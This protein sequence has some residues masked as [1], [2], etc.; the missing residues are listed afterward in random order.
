MSKLKIFLSN[1]NATEIL[2]ALDYDSSTLYL[3]YQH[4]VWGSEDNLISLFNILKDAEIKNL[5]FIGLFA[6][7]KCPELLAEFL[8]NPQCHIT[9]INIDS[10]FVDYIGY[11]KFGILLE[12][13]KV[14]NS[15]Q[16]INLGNA[17]VAPVQFFPL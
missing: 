15:L 13:F 4:S 14:N 17:R 6:I 11:E 12:A 1:I 8:K 7:N 3:N 9:G 5:V 16:E 2:E 10:E